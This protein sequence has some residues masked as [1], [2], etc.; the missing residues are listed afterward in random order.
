VAYKAEIDVRVKR[1]G[2]EAVL[3]TDDALEVWV[4]HSLIDEDSDI[5]AD[6][7]EGDE[8]TLIIP[9]WK[10]EELELV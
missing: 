7:V 3:V 10:A 9:Q 8:G 4:P 5:T 2:E 6:S 1:Q